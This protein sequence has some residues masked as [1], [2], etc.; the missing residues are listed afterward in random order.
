MALVATDDKKFS[1]YT[2]VADLGESTPM[3]NSLE[4]MFDME[5]TDLST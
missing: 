2:G 4:G 3:C 1:T 5:N